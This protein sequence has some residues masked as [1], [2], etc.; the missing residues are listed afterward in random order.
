MENIWLIVTSLLSMCFPMEFVS[1]YQPD[2]SR[3]NMAVDNLLNKQQ[4]IAPEW[5]LM[6]TSIEQKL[7]LEMDLLRP[8]TGLEFG[9]LNL[10]HKFSSEFVGEP[11]G[12]K[13]VE[14]L[15]I[16]SFNDSIV[17]IDFIQ[18]N[19]D[20]Y[21]NYIFL[22]FNKSIAIC[23]NV[24]KK[25]KVH[26]R[27]HFKSSV[28]SS[29]VVIIDG[30]V[31]TFTLNIKHEVIIMHFNP[32]L[33]RLN[34]TSTLYANAVGQKLTSFKVP[35]TGSWILAVISVSQ[36]S[37]YNVDNY[38]GHLDVALCDVLIG[39]AIS[40][41]VMFSINA[42]LYLAI[43]NNNYS[44]SHV[45]KLTAIN[46][47]F[48]FHHG[49]AIKNAMSIEYF[50]HN[51]RHFLMISNA[52]IL[53]IYRWES[54]RFYVKQS[55][56][57]NPKK[58]LIVVNHVA[59]VY[60]NDGL[61]LPH[62][63]AYGQ[64]NRF[65][66]S[67]SAETLMDN[68]PPFDDWMTVTFKGEALIMMWTNKQMTIYRV[69]LARIKPILSEKEKAIKKR[70]VY[71][72]KQ[73]D[74]MGDLAKQMSK[75]EVVVNDKN[76]KEVN[77]RLEKVSRQTS[78]LNAKLDD[79]SIKW[80]WVMVTGKLELRKHANINFLN[81]VNVT[82]WFSDAVK[83]RDLKR[84]INGFKRFRGGVTFKN[85][86]NVI[87]W[88]EKRFPEDY[89]ITNLRQNSTAS[90]WTVVSD[91]II[92][93]DIAIKG[94]INSLNV[95]NDVIRLYHDKTS[96]KLIGSVIFT[97]R[98]TSV[99]SV[100]VGGRVNGHSIFNVANFVIT[101]NGT[102]AI[103]QPTA[104]NKLKVN[105]NFTV[106]QVNGFSLKKI[107]SEILDK[108]KPCVI[109]GKKLI[110]GQLN[111]DGNVMLKTINGMKFPEDFL[112][113]NSTQTATKLYGLKRFSKELIIDGS[114]DVDGQLSNVYM[115]DLFL[116]RGNQE[117]CG[118]KT[119]NEV[120]G[121]KLQISDT[122]LN[123]ETKFTGHFK[124]IDT[125][126]GVNVNGIKND[127]INRGDD[128]NITFNNKVAFTT[129]Q[130]LTDANLILSGPVNGLNVDTDFVKFDADDNVLANKTFR[131]FVSFA[132]NLTI[133]GNINGLNVSNLREN[134]VSFD[135][136]HQVIKGKKMFYNGVTVKS[137][138]IENYNNRNPILLL[139]QRITVNKVV[140]KRD[141]HV[142]GLV[143]DRNFEDL[144][145]KRVTLTTPQNFRSN[146]RLDATSSLINLNVDGKL[147]GINIDRLCQDVLWRERHGSE[148][149][150]VT[151]Q[152]ILLGRLHTPTVVTRNGIN[153]VS[154]SR[155]AYRS[156]FIENNRNINVSTL[157]FTSIEVKGTRG[158]VIDGKLSG[159]NASRVFNEY[160]N[161][162]QLDG[163]QFKNVKIFDTLNINGS[164]W[165]SGGVNGISASKQ[166]LTTTT[167]QNITGNLSFC[168]GVTAADVVIIDHLIEEL[169]RKVKFLRLF[170]NVSVEELESG[171]DINGANLTEQLLL[172]KHGHMNAKI[173]KGN[174]KFLKHLNVVG[175]INGYDY[176]DRFKH[177]V[178]KQH[179]NITF[180]A[181]KE[182]KSDI[183]VISAV[184]GPLAF[185]GLL[186]GKN[187][188][189]VIKENGTIDGILEIVGNVEVKKSLNSGNQSVVNIVGDIE[190]NS[191]D[192]VNLLQVSA[193]TLTLNSDQ[194]VT[195]YKVFSGNVTVEED[196]WITFN[197]NVTFVFGVN[198]TDFCP[199][200]VNIP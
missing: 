8:S 191:V 150:V 29:A 52:D 86:S 20:E 143:N 64:N 93:K 90:D 42:E 172:G 134:L 168:G 89:I 176:I 60:G 155:V 25:I 41:V 10:N 198:V 167:R 17:D 63:L 183:K 144:A 192:G 95:S 91:V 195:G 12:V 173:F 30:D 170:G 92:E 99:G 141:A 121:N 194:R 49:L 84:K 15:L 138:I 154:L 23:S 188:E 78:D 6:T 106:N 116:L 112:M 57:N 124:V 54:K 53:L 177:I 169:T 117:I 178:T 61:I 126:N 72:A 46:G 98:L 131:S 87:D 59:D 76:C 33:D 181:S 21:S 77:G 190:A 19:D 40:D 186:K 69:E 66:Y 156:I 163:Y 18:I 122:Y 127:V 185:D 85:N 165:V 27:I 118:H 197:R 38:N 123:N 14:K 107:E 145:N 37:V 114:L 73:L 50:C 189:I 51:Y 161:A 109:T 82:H 96:Q 9:D 152:K 113:Y 83:K 5:A 24:N 135:G 56:P 80:S 146:L 103:L 67:R 102:K 120:V 1:F 182:F 32:L 193:D 35:L 68:L 164:L 125:I 199:V 119:F 39:S 36:V 7:K 180:S 187:N 16:E 179:T 171:G 196:W 28:T 130:F 108:N 71:F 75:H 129:K 4:N 153:G 11:L 70:L 81:G 147:N 149:R 142:N 74:L 160:L 140:I 133:R 47:H 137:I 162:S 65:V 45:W 151:G 158:L 58:K 200:N 31:F 97:D 139:G 174:L 148:K 105:G 136:Q 128:F 44:Q 34:M 43:A 166:L 100:N 88:N 175:G 2:Y 79:V 115:N 110:M 55:L 13:S 104:F 159:H 26:Q 157:K 3:L 101:S 94:H 48:V 111:I 132:G 62:C 184:I 22:T